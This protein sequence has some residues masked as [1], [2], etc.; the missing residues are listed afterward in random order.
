MPDSRCFSLSSSG[1]EGWGEEAV[2]SD[3]RCC[4]RLPPRL[5]PSPRAPLAGRG[6]SPRRQCEAPRPLQ[7]RVPASRGALIFCHHSPQYPARDRAVKRRDSYLV[8]SN[9]ERIVSLSPALD[10]QGS[11]GGG[12]TLGKRRI[13]TTNPES[14]NHTCFL[15]FSVFRLGLQPSSSRLSFGRATL[16]AVLCC[17][18]SPL[19]RLCSNLSVIT[20]D[21]GDQVAIVPL[22]IDD[23]LDIVRQHVNKRGWT[24]TFN[25]WAGDGGWRSAPAKAFR[26]SGVPTTYIIDAQGKIVRAGHP[27]AMTIDEIVDAMLKS[28]KE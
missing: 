11:K 8:S 21:W 23:T 15:R 12:P 16:A 28:A 18:R 13:W 22:S 9:P 5:C 26:V 1:G 10:R 4:P 17:P 7:G 14:G 2:V 25:V 20:F 6:S 3:S 27:A 24:N 19:R